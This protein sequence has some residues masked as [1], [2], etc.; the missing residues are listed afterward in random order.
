MNSQ[1]LSSINIDNFKNLS[2]GDGLKLN[3][4]NIFIG[5]NGSGKSNVIS[6]LKF[7]KDCVGFGAENG[8]RGSRFEN[9]VAQL[10]GSNLLDKSLT[11][12]SY[13][14]LSYHFNPT[15][16][17]PKGLNLNL[18]LFAG[19]KNSKV[20][21]GEESLRDSE[22]IDDRPFY[23]YRHHDKEVGKGVVSYYNDLEGQSSHFEAIDDV[24]NNSLG[25]ISTY[26]FLEGSENPPEKTPIYKV[27]RELIEYIAQWRFYNANDMNLNQIRTS[28]PK[29][30]PGDIYLS[31]SGHNLALVVENLFQQHIDFEDELNK[32]MRSIIPITR[33][34]R[35][36]RTGL[37]SINLQWYYEGFDDCFYLN[38]MSDGTVKMLCWATILL[39]PE[40]PSL[41]VIDEP[42][43]GVHV[44]W[45][46]V[47][48]EWIKLAS[49]RTQVII[50]THSP[51]LLDHFTD[52]LENVYCF[53]TE[54]KK[55]FSAQTLSRDALSS[56]LDEGWKLGDLYRVGDP[57]VGGWPW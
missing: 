45:M 20:S 12:P 46:P 37:M 43:L 55:R 22:V 44:S 19:S 1:N 14:H 26:K 51:D 2:M 36:A 25:L 5:P 52:C 18:K 53:T 6:V 31:P 11:P 28:E 39:S 54:D 24:P 38:E 8:Q 32:A 35:P 40:A 48:A 17:L 47:L 29:I 23:Y 21:I 7:L 41:L 27:G 16:A 4:L 13:V 57:L 50:C 10:G 34:F 56:K 30:G 15:A 49:Q 9:A 42:E 33:R 3:G